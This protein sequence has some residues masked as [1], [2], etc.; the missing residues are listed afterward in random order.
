MQAPAKKTKKV[1]DHDFDMK[2]DH[3]PADER[4]GRRAQREAK[5]KAEEEKPA[6]EKNKYDVLGDLD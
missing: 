2:H 3:R 4:A 1:E 6:K 5:K